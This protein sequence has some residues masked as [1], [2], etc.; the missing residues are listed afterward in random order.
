MKTNIL[1]CLIL[2]SGMISFNSCDDFLEISPETNL[3]DATFYKTESHF[4]QAL[5]GAYQSLRGLV[6]PGIFMDEMRTDNT[7][8][9]YYMPDRGPADW[10][11]DI[12]QWTD[13]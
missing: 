7:F 11:E 5:V 12:I 13:Q 8:F 10:V 3:T 9:R 2:I 1:F 6:Y 4:E